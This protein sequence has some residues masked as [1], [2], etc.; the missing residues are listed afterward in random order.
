MDLSDCQQN[1][2]CPSRHPK[3]CK[4]YASGSCRFQSECAYSHHNDHK[5]KDKCE[6]TDKIDI[7]EKIVREI[8]FKFMKVDQELKVM[9]E[10]IKVHEMAVNNKVADAKEREYAAEEE[11]PKANTCKKGTDVEKDV[12]IELTKDDKVLN[13]VDDKEETYDK[14]KGAMYHCKDCGYQCKKEVTLNKHVNT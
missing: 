10:Q 13:K 3:T 8:T 2:T 14:S 11:T 4:R 7:L 1:K 12:A 5:L 6:H 9:K